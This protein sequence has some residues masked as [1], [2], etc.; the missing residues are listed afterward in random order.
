M[1]HLEHC[2]LLE[3]E[4]GRFADLVEAVAPSTPVS[5]C[6]GWN[7]ADLTQHMG[8][9]HRWAEHLVRVGA[10]E[11]IPHPEIGPEDGPVDADFIRRGGA[12]L[13]KT[14]RTA[15][16]LVPMW[17][18]G[19]DQHVRFWSRRELHETLVHRVDVALADGE[20]PS[21]PAR[22]AVDTID[23]FLA[24]LPS[25]E[26][27]SPAVSRLRGEGER[28]LFRATDTGDAWTVALLPDRI[29]VT[30]GESPAAA[31]VSAPAATLC[32]VMYRRLPMAG[33]GLIVEDAGGLV[34]FWI[35]HSALE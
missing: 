17:A 9:V 29:D 20:R 14:L 6:P 18:W 15:D 21:I 13:L 22:I 28:I 19:A 1:D 11:R 24:N 8:T 4:I 27:F 5:T 10:T 31:T 32:L 2:D 35:A 26:A 34:D 30:K 7:V 23:E 3:V 16:P 12:A 25:T 33:A